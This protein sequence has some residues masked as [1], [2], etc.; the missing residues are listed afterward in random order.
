M[1]VE[2]QEKSKRLQVGLENPA[3]LIR[4]MN[5]RSLHHFVRWAWPILISQPYVDNFHIIYLCQEL[6]KVAYQVGE[7]KPKIH[8]LL[9]NVPPGST[10][11]LLCTIL[12]PVWCW[13]KWHWM[14]FITASYS[15]GLA[16][17][18]AESSRDLIKSEE[19]KQIYPDLEIKTDKDSKTNYRIAKRKKDV[20]GKYISRKRGAWDLG[21]F[22]YSTSVGGTLTGY[23]GDICI[24]DDPLN[25][26]QAASQ[27]VIET[28]N[29]WIDQTLPTRKTNKNN[30]VI[31]GIMQRLAE[32][33][34]T[35]H[36]LKKKKPNLKHICLPGEIIGYGD[37]VKPEGL[38]KYYKNGLFDPNR[39]SAKILAELEI[40]LGQYGYAGQIGQAPAPIGGGMFKV[41]NIVVTNS[42]DPLD[43]VKTVRYWD[44]ASTSLGGTYTA[45]VKIARLRNKKFV[46]LDVK[47]GQWGTDKRERIMRNVAEADGVGTMIVIEQE[48]GSG[49]KD[50]AKGS[51][52]NLAGFSVYAEKPT[53]NKADRADPFSVQVNNGNVQM[54]VAVWNLDFTRELELF[55]NSTYKDQTDAA[56]GAFNIL[57]RKKDVK[58]I[59]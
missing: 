18:S 30:S 51:I 33:D 45:G 4:E 41:D 52:L 47:R 21:G 38:K 32:N 46:I 19:F 36:L 58:R 48:P 11:T 3:L 7:R 50:S 35:G 34:P 8:D 9:I 6:E 55:P 43:I 24:W 20:N 42:V 40:D 16:L 23:H 10:K 1:E 25:P 59:T 31:I 27:N 54:L 28:A 26:Q 22:R 29:R 44:K 39:L 5:N 56:S 49:G 15:G 17:E 14:R 37:L 57:M 53:G 13:T 12:F 2:V